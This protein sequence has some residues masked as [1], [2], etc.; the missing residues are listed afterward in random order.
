[1]NAV[2]DELLVIPGSPLKF[3]LAVIEAVDSG[4]LVLGESAKPAIYYPIEAGYRVRRE[5]IPHRIELFQEALRGLLGEGATIIERLIAKNLH[6]KLGM[7][8]EEHKNWALSDYIERARNVG[9]EC[10]RTKRR[11]GDL[12]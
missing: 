9:R 11:E 8:Y 7:I 6:S 10:D 3:E 1:M 4:L 12:G 2:L 5:D